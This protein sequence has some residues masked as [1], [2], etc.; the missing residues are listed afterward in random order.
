MIYLD[1]SVALAWVRTE[2]RRPDDLLW[3][4]PMLSSRL[5]QYEVWNRLHAYEATAHRQARARRVLNKLRWIELS[6][7]A[8]VRALRPWPSAVR[9][10]DGLHLATMD[11]LKRQ[12]GRVELASYDARLL[13]AATAM[14]FAT[15]EP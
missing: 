1:S 13:A 11:F 4:R 15:L 6:D 10:L 2:D 12:G 7:E 3:A 14:G 5:L 9:T 8:L